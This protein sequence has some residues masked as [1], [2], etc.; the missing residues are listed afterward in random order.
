METNCQRK[1]VSELSSGVLARRPAG[2]CALH[3]R[4]LGNSAKAAEHTLRPPA[5]S[6]AIKHSTAANQRVTFQARGPVMDCGFLANTRIGQQSSPF[7]TKLQL[8]APSPPTLHRP[9]TPMITTPERDSTPFCRQ[10]FT[11]MCRLPPSTPWMCS[12]LCSPHH[13]PPSIPPPPQTPSNPP[14]PLTRPS[15]PLSALSSPRRPPS[16]P[17][18]PPH[19]HCLAA[20]QLQASTLRACLRCRRRV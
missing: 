16:T 19:R 7:E 11:A 3:R 2:G 12:C 1:D 14:K 10:N 5:Y 8:H 13:H 4:W 9:Y 15:D 17:L 6:S 20:S 18:P